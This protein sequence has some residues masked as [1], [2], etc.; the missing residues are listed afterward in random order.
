[1]YHDDA[2]MEVSH[3][4]DS[5]WADDAPVHDAVSAHS[6]AQV[7]Q[8]EWEK[9]SLRYSDVSSRQFKFVLMILKTSWLTSTASP[10][11]HRQVIV[12]ASP[13]ARMLDCKLGS[14]KD[15]HS[16]LPLHEN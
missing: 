8:Q 4:D 15:S 14:T 9:L 1:M 16:P 12:M 3:E 7:A 5:I 6:G 11:K 10:P 13:L 2:P